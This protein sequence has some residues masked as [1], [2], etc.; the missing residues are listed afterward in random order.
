MTHT[1]CWSQ[2]RPEPLTPLS[3]IHRP[4]KHNR[5][6]WRSLRGDGADPSQELVPV[7]LC[8][9]PPCNSLHLTNCLSFVESQKSFFFFL[10]REVWTY[11][12]VSYKS[13]ETHWIHLRNKSVLSS[14]NS[15]LISYDYELISQNY[16]LMSHNC[17]FISHNHELIS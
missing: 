3:L 12:P 4:L 7:C 10:K 5:N 2:M 14:H 9:S 17:D 16:D 15:D 6:I 13:T 11:G 1:D 8:W